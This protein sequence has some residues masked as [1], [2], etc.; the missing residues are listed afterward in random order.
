M[1]YAR[2]DNNKVV[3]VSKNNPNI[4]GWVE[5][6]EEWSNEGRNI[7]NFI[8]VGGVVTPPSPTYLVD[9]EWAIIRENRDLLLT[10]SDFR[11]ASDYP[12]DQTA[13][14]TY[15]QALR[16]LPTISLDPFSVV[17]PTPPQ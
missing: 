6:P 1:K 15:R 14:K 10:N 8:M 7:Y 12:G 17:L 13:Y 9:K 2:I 11:V 5:I 4:D 16:D 3:E